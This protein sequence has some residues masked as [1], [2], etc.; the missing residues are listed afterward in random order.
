MKIKIPH[1]KISA[2][3]ILILCIIGTFLSSIGLSMYGTVH[4]PL[5]S[6]SYKLEAHI[7][8]VSEDKEALKIIK[9]NEN[10][11]IL[12]DD[13]PTISEK[14]NKSGWDLMGQ[15]GKIRLSGLIAMLLSILAFFCRPWWVG[16]IALP[17]GIYSLNLSMVIM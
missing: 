3:Y 2:W 9:N 15:A 4:W 8:N 10:L 17:F 13:L 12:F 14:I 7:G 5:L 6:S 1:F 11:K 16:F